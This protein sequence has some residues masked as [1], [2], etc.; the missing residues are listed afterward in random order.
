MA[1]QTRA[2]LNAAVPNAA[3][4]PPQH[5][6]TSPLIPT[7]VV[8]TGMPIPPVDRIK[9]FSSKQW[10]EFVTEWIDSLRTKY[11]DV[12]PLG[13]SGDMGRD[14]VATYKDDVDQWDNYQ[15]KHYDH[16]LWPSDIWIELG[17]LAYYSRRGDYTYPQRYF[18]IAPQGA[19]TTLSNLLKKPDKLRAEL[20]ANWEREC[21]TKITAT[22]NVDL[23]DSLKAY[24]N[25][26]DFSIFEAVSPLRI[27]DEHAKTPWYAARF[28]GGLP[29]RPPVIPPPSIPT[30]LE[31]TYVR[32]LLDAY[33]D[34]LKRPVPAVGDLAAEQELNEH[35]KDSRIDFYSAEALRA[36]SRDTLPPGQFE[37]L[38]D[39][40]HTGIKDDVRA[41]HPSGYE[42]VLAAAKTARLL[43]LSNHALSTRMSLNDRGGV[44]HQLANDSKVRWVKK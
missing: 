43:P 25:G 17:K 33:A 15:C 11:R 6:P 38:Q 40:I 22:A 13:G 28:G 14:V 30:P 44:C 39:E 42:R 12:Q 10:E 27:L 31:A 20:L 4:L 21:R 7:D 23:D 3:A 19:G 16:P 8:A 32:Q 34:H 2:S 5:A 37:K 24:I 36:F 26:L 9:I 29:M 18:F 1:K 41:T 35:F